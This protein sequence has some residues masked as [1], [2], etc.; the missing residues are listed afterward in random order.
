MNRLLKSALLAAALVMFSLQ[1]GKVFSS[2][3]HPPKFVRGKLVCAKNTN[4]FLKHIGKRWTG[5]NSAQS[6]LKFQRVII[7]RS[8]DVAV[9]RRPG[10]W[11]SQNVDGIKRGIAMCW[12]PSSKLQKWV[13][14]SCNASW[15]RVKKIYVRTK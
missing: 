14:Q 2:N 9:N 6:F 12:N 11:H 15:S 3:L 13:Y 4:L 5:S 7:P 1:V 10:G 8:G